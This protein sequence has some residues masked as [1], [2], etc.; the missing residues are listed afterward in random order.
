MTLT[1]F[2]F[3]WILTG[4]FIFSKGEKVMKKFDLAAKV[5]SVSATCL[6]ISAL[7]TTGVQ[8]QV[9]NKTNPNMILDQF[10][11]LTYNPSTTL[12]WDY[13]WVTLENNDVNGFTRAENVPCSVDN[14]ICVKAMNDGDTTFARLSET[15]QQY[16]GGFVL[17]ELSA[18]RD[19][20]T[21][22]Q[23]HRWLPTVGHPVVFS[24]KVRWGANYQADGSGTVGSSGVYLWN[25]PIDLINNAFNAPLT[26]G[27]QFSQKGTKLSNGPSD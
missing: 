3:S 10:K 20:F 2:F 22:G 11:S 1:T 15:H 23:T 14:S 19:G 27:F 4:I 24:E 16:P 8:A 12:P 18:E 21:Y 6:A 17:A 25:A 13:W 26:M 5:F 7:L 9:V